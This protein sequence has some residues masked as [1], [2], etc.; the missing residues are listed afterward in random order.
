LI[1]L[2]SRFDPIASWL[3][4]EWAPH[5]A[6]LLTCEDLSHAGWVHRVSDP[7]AG[8]VAVA[9]RVLPTAS[10]RAVLTLLPSVAPTELRT[11]VEHDREYVAQEIMAF[12]LAWLG[13]LGARAVNRP[14]TTCLMGPHWRQER[15]VR[16]AR[17]LGLPTMAVER[18]VA[19]GASPTA[20]AMATEAVAVVGERAFAEDGSP[21]PPFRHDAAVRLARAAHADLLAVRFAGDAVVDARL[22][23][24]LR[25]SPVRAAL[26]EHLLRVGA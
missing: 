25:L 8:Q 1:I 18:R 21:A 24:D 9:G 5:D 22:W 12:L 23:P 16:A 14:T 11:I 6:A 10:V 15:W 17:E 3:A 4:S 20:T 19:L 7:S 2:A 13:A 26:C